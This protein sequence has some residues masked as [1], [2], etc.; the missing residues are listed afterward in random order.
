MLKAASSDG[1]P[2]AEADCV[3]AEAAAGV[4]A[5]AAAGAAGKRQTARQKV[6]CSITTSSSCDPA[7]KLPHSSMIC[8][9]LQRPVSFF[10]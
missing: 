1:D 10:V 8:Y 6:L 2:G 4:P 5:E 3:V 7:R 9:C